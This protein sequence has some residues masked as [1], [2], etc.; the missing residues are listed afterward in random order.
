[1]RAEKRVLEKRQVSKKE[2][3]KIIKFAARPAPR[4]TSVP[5]KPHGIPNKGKNKTIPEEFKLT[6]QARGKKAKEEWEKKTQQELNEIKE[7]MLFKSGAMP[8]YPSFKPLT[9]DA[10]PPTQTI[11]FQF[12]LE[13]R[14]EERNKFF[15]EQESKR[16]QEELKRQEEEEQRK[17]EELEEVKELR[18]QMV[19]KHR[20]ITKGKP[21]V[22]QKSCTVLTRPKS[23]YL[24]TSQRVEKDYE[25]R[26]HQTYECNTDLSS[27]KD[28]DFHHS[29]SSDH[30][31]IR[32]PQRTQQ[33][34][35][36][37]FDQ[38]IPDNEQITQDKNQI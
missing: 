28:S 6:T 12:N 19:F 9:K 38:I 36:Q 13:K 2:E 10:P 33:D 18:K 35:F 25:Q 17:Q 27:F 11:A 3:A 23:P 30:D 31:Y 15:H 5:I 20:S 22:I 24:C 14:C 21:L 26:R 16:K 32:I 4:S 8:K 37:Q 34:V 1:L 7:Q 29:P